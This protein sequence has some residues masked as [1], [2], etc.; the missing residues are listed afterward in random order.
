MDKIEN[1]KSP[2]S[3]QSIDVT[4]SFLPLSPNSSHHLFI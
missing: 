2:T 3:D 1:L 4:F